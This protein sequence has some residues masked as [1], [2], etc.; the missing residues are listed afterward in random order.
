MRE[1]QEVIKSS[2]ALIV[3]EECLDET[4]V[5]SWVVECGEERRIAKSSRSPPEVLARSTS[6]RMNGLERVLVACKVPVA[7][8]VEHRRPFQVSREE[9]QGKNSQPQKVCKGQ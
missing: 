3:F 4:W 1:V 2:E 7:S 5:T 9:W 8:P 6:G